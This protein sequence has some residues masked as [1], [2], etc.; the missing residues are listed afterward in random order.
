MLTISLMGWKSNKD[1][2]GARPINSQKEMEPRHD[3][4]LNLYN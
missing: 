2:E 4:Y 1:G 3:A